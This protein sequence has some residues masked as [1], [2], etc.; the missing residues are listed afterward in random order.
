MNSFA[1]SLFS[2]LFGWAKSLIQHI[3]NG[4]AAGQYSGFLTWLGDHWLIVAAILCLACTVIDFIIWL[5]RWR[6][7][8]VWRSFARRLGGLFHRD[9]PANSRRFAKGFKGGVSLDLPPV[10]REN[11]PQADWE[12]DIQ[13][14]APLWQAQQSMPS[15]PQTVPQAGTPAGM[16]P[17]EDGEVPVSAYEN[18]PPYVEPVPAFASGAAEEEARQRHFVPPAYEPPPLYVSARQVSGYSTGI[19][20]AR[21][22][23]SE[24][25]EKRRPEWQK[26]FIRGDEE[27]DSLLDGLPPAVDRQEAFHEPVY[28]RNSVSSNSYAGW[29]RPA[30]GSDQMDGQA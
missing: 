7:Y 10:E 21:R 22:R 4:A 8:W 23:R 19:P 3:W 1:N 13:E 30:S 27:E 9:Q 26:R 25:Y 2:L 16:Y 15:F 18:I 28:P 11:V 6:P 14:Q 24:R 29:Q 20:T 12:E 5:I 17:A